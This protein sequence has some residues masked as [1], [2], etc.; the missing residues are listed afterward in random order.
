VT[1][2]GLVG[3][4]Q[5]K[6]AFRA[7]YESGTTQYDYFGDG[8]NILN[9]LAFVALLDSVYSQTKVLNP[10][11]VRALTEEVFPRVLPSF[12]VDKEARPYGYGD[13]LSWEVG[14][15]ETGRVSYLSSTLPIEGIAVFGAI[16]GVTIWPVVFMLP[17]LL[18]FGRISSFAVPTATSIFLLSAFHWELIEGASDTFIGVA[19]RSIPSAV[20]RFGS[21]TGGRSQV[22]QATDVRLGGPPSRARRTVEGTARA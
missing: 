14:L 13:W 11:G 21:C 16:L 2:P 3:E 18:L 5:R 7:R 20:I 8:S 12:L 22:R 10:I 6:D 4:L 19:T 9:R 15:I 1:E 17:M